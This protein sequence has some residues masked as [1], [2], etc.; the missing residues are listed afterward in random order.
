MCRG[1]PLASVFAATREIPFVYKLQPPGSLYDA[2]SDSF[3]ISR[4]GLS[5]SGETLGDGPAIVLLHGLTATRRYVVHGSKLL[6]RRGWRM[7]AYDARG[8]GDS[9][10]PDDR[11]AYEYTDLAEDLRAVLDGL[12]IEKA[13]LA[14]SSMGAAAA[15]R[16]ALDSPDRV[17]ALVQITPAFDDERDEDDLDDWRA[18]ADGLD[19]DGVD[20]FLAA[21]DPPVSGDFRETVMTF[22]RQRLERHRSLPAVA[23]ALR[24][25]PSSRAFDGL[26]ALQAVEAPTLIVASRDEADP[27]HPRKVAE[28]YAEYLPNASL[29][30]EDEGESPIAWQGAQLSR[31]IV[32]FLVRAQVG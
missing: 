32:D 28:A 31:A 18:L 26:E 1:L 22:T 11:A 14:G 30:V 10:A 27:G 21:Y 4:D 6:S 8:H 7:V 24:V 25:V 29:I 5:L 15:L 17:L 13:V 16:F 23:D 20:G 12:G 19:A 9:G 3:D 2:I